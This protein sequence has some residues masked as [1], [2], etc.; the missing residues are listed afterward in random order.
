MRTGPRIHDDVLALA[1]EAGIIP[2]A[3]EVG[4]L[5]VVRGGREPD[6]LDGAVARSPPSSR[7]TNACSQ[8]ASWSLAPSNVERQS[9]IA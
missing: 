6:R 7:M 5:L 2:A 9:F 4:A 3:A 1:L 8:S